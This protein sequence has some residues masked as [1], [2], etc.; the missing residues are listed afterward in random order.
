MNMS[1]LQADT[2]CFSVTPTDDQTEFLLGRRPW[3]IPLDSLQGK[4]GGVT[5]LVTGA[6]GFIGSELCRMLISLGATVIALDNSEYGLASLQETIEDPNLTLVL[7]DIRDQEAVENTLKLHRPTYVYHAAAYKHVPFLESFVVEAI[8]NNTL[9]AW[10]L[11]HACAQV[12]VERF[13][14][15]SS[16]KAACPRNVLG[17]SKRVAEILIGNISE[18]ATNF[19]SVRCAN[20]L[21]SPGSVLPRAIDQ[22][23]RGGPVTVTSLNSRRYFVTVSEAARAILYARQLTG[24]GAVFIPDA[25]KPVLILDLLT[26]LIQQ[27][28]RQIQTEVVG[29]R[30]GDQ[31]DEVLFA[32]EETPE[33]TSCGRMWKI[34][35]ERCLSD[36]EQV[37]IVQNLRTYCATR[38]PERLRTYLHSFLADFI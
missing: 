30:R 19:A 37:T 8:R 32:S 17:T 10:E 34:L 22:I 14:F 31:D 28:G 20:V 27:T 6:G 33:L 36:E 26:R 3:Q 4:I 25:G 24:P 38:E 1:G 2:R 35:P 16:D 21:G 29:L 9:A 13:V 18:G 15:V 7:A 12:G 5:A 23:A 11:A